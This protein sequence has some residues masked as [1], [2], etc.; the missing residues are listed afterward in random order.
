[1]VLSLIVPVYNVEA[2]LHKCVDSLLNQNLNQD[3]YE[4]ILI[5][6]G[7]TDGSG[8]ICDEYSET[9]S[10][11]RVIHQK[12]EGLSS[13]RN[14]GICQATGQYLQ[15]V[16]SDDFLTAN[17]L[18]SI[19]TQIQN[20]HLDVLR[21]NYQNVDKSGK[22][23]Q[24]NKT[25][26]LFV[27]YSPIPCNGLSFLN[28]RLGYACYAVQFL[29]R[30]ELLKSNRILFADGMYYE[31][32]EWTPR[33]ILTAN[34][35]AST[36]TIVYNYTFRSDSITKSI[37]TDK[38]LKLI[39]DRMTLIDS[40]I[41]LSQSITDVNWLKGMIAHIVVSII[42]DVS[43]YFFS[44]RHNYI[45]ALRAKRVF[46]LITYHSTPTA[47]RKIALINMSP[48][49]ACLAMHLKMSRDS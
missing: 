30:S 11:I 35:I 49:L 3:D 46:P 8:K 32:A 33:M 43:R 27:D 24:L 28:E 48:E 31:D 22:V 41:R 47:K 40:Y 26:K 23:I 38:R 37:A 34:R 42:S 2:Y 13:A 15:F 44:V 9:F 17:V 12:N 16:D 45:R 19:L 39:E 21:F 7:S 10:N 25:P 14:R 6:D 20:N 29:V 36:D 18:G 1:M 4:I 5:D